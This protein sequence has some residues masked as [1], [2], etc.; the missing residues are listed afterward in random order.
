MAIA[1]ALGPNDYSKEFEFNVK[2]LPIG[3]KLVS[4]SYAAGEFEP[5]KFSSEQAWLQFVKDTMAAQLVE[6]MLKEKLI[7]FT[8]MRDNADTMTRFNARCYL[9]KDDQVRLLRTHYK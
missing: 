9:T 3:G 5:A 1:T 6:Y 4:V 7:E 2:D 8:K